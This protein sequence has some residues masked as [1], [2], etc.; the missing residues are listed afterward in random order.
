MATSSIELHG[1]VTTFGMD[2]ACSAAMLLQRFPKSKIIVTSAR[3]IALTLEDILSEIPV[4]QVV[5]ICGV[6][7]RDSPEQVADQL[8]MLAEKNCQ[9]IWYCGRGYLNE[10]E[11]LLS[12]SCKPVF[13]DAAS[14]TEIVQLFYNIPLS[15]LVSLFLTLARQFVEEKKR[16]SKNQRFW[17]DLIA[18]SASRYFKYGDVKSYAHSILKLANLIAVADADREDVEA[19]RLSKKY[20]VPLG[21]SPVIKNLRSVIKR[22]GPI[23]EPALILGPTGSGKEIA[24]RILHEASGRSGPFV[25]VNCAVLSTSSDLAHDRL[26]GHVSGAYTGAKESQPGAFE[27]ADGGTLFLDE[28]VELPISVQTQLLRV[29]EERTVTP[30]GTMQSRIVNVRIVAASNQNIS[31]LIREGK[32]RSDLYHRLNV[33]QIEIPP[34]KDRMEDMKSIAINTM[35]DL[36]K[37]GYSYSLSE[38][39]WAAAYAYDWPGNIRQFINLLKRAVYMKEPFRQILQNEIRSASSTEESRH[40]DFSKELQLFH[41][42]NPSEVKPEAQIRRSYMKHVLSLFE[43]NWTKAAD[44]LD[45][46]INTLRKWT[47][48][49]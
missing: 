4:L 6:G 45:V 16:C 49:S 38:E 33:L 27:I 10:Y 29:L 40:G 19:F 13:M 23:E 35:Y 47:G 5:H 39:D 11:E 8:R 46:S 12:E 15:P 48:E 43:G 2:G 25:P 36:R 24:A 42:Q 14:N 22:L 31:C 26:F 30:L 44:A 18:F 32:F 28:L 41:P 37:K 21:E 20:D 7:I 34:L 1:I 3:R 9:V 17:H